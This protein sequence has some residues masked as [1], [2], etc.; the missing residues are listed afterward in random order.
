MFCCKTILVQQGV[1]IEDVQLNKF[2]VYR[3][4]KYFTIRLVYDSRK[5]FKEYT[6]FL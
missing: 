4:N 3:K 5:E 6:F 1:K 2:M